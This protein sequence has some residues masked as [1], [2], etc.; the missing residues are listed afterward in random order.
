LN[1][2]ITNRFYSGSDYDASQI[3]TGVMPTADGKSAIVYVNRTYTS[4]VTGFG[5]S[6]KRSIGR[7]MMK[8]KI[9]ETMKKAQQV[10]V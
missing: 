3:V 10:L 7:K 4:S 1:R 6:T 8:G 5:G 2:S 9:V